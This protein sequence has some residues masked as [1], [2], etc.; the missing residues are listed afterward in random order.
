MMGRKTGIV[1]GPGPTD[2]TE[3]RCGRKVSW[4]GYC[5]GF[6]AISQIYLDSNQSST[7]HF[8]STVAVHIVRDNVKLGMNAWTEVHPIEKLV[9]DNNKRFLEDIRQDVL[10]FRADACL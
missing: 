7:I 10:Y 6:A 8:Q 9:I 4:I 5:G 1:T 2:R 3:V